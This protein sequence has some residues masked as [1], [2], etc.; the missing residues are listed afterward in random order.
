MGDHAHHYEITVY[1]LKV[2]QLPLDSSASGAAVGFNLHA[3]M[4]AT[5]KIVGR[6]GRSK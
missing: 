1:A 3:N 2:A 5:A 6:Y 4:L